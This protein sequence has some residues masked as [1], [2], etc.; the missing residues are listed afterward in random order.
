MHIEWAMMLGCVVLG[1]LFIFPPAVQDAVLSGSFFPVTTSLGNFLNEIFIGATAADT[2]LLIG[3]VYSIT[4]LGSF[5]EFSGHI[6]KLM[7]SLSELMKDGRFVIATAP[8]LIGLMPMPGGALFSCP[9]VNDVGSKMNIEPTRMAAIN[10]WFRHVWEYVWPLYPGLILMSA[11]FS[12]DIPRIMLA[13]APLAIGT[14]L[15]GLIF[16]IFPIKKPENNGSV[17]T[18]SENIREIFLALWPL[19]IIIFFTMVPYPNHESLGIEKDTLT[20]SK[21][22]LGLILSTIFYGTFNRINWNSTFGVLIICLKKHTVMVALSIMLFKHLV[23]IT[24]AADEMAPFFAHLGLP[25]VVVI[26]L[27]CF[28]VGLLT[29]L[30]VGYVGICFPIIAPFIQVNG[31]TDPGLMQFAFATGFIGVMLTPV[32]LCFS[33]TREYFDVEWGDVYK[34]ILPCAILIL[35]LS[36]IIAL[37]GLPNWV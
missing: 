28:I 12:V 19:I 7:E 17:H 25:P 3:M 30:T 29:G 4:V 24:G 21:L 35:L 15:T 11:I 6:K 26:F 18:I 9:M 13:Q 31:S 5:M 37:T 22:L 34:L 2:L 10:F 8:S 27:L 1:L 23:Q 33:L 32:H 14:I 20:R 36:F 16:L